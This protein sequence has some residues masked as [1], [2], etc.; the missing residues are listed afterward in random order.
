VTLRLQMENDTPASMATETADEEV[1]EL[2]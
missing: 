2:A 1:L